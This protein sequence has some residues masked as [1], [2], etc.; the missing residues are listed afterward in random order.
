MVD[1]CVLGLSMKYLPTERVE[2]LKREF[3]EYLAAV[4]QTDPWLREHPP[5]V[6]WSASG[7]SFPP[8]EIP[9]DHPLAEAVAAAYRSVVGEPRWAGFEA[10]SDIAWFA[11]AGVPALLY[12]PGDAAQAHTT[13]EYLEIDDLLTATKVVTLAVAGWSG[14]A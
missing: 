14:V 12:G 6:E 3:E 1:R 2:D 7:V 4:A 11:E 8:S 10:V 13:E 5:T 9:L